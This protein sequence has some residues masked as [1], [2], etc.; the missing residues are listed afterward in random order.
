MS[1]SHVSG[2][3]VSVAGASTVQ[4]IAVLRASQC[5]L[6]WLVWWVKWLNGSPSASG[7]AGFAAGMNVWTLSVVPVAF[8]RATHHVCW[9]HLSVTVGVS[10][11][12]SLKTAQ[13][14]T[15]GP[16]VFR[17]CCSGGLVRVTRW[18]IRSGVSVSSVPC[19]LSIRAVGWPT[20]TSHAS[21]V[22]A[23]VLAARVM[24]SSVSPPTMKY[25]PPARVVGSWA[26]CFMLRCSSALSGPGAFG[27]TGLGSRAPRPANG[28]YGL[29]ALGSRGPRAMW[30]T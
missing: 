6:G 29:S 26:V 5:A 15:F 21:V 13:S 7:V 9:W 25:F 28:F 11:G 20:A 3:V 12:L 8:N 22:A 2:S 16:L 18:F 19:T 14:V 23:R 4:C 30:C 27:S 24:T 17:S 1:L 10:G